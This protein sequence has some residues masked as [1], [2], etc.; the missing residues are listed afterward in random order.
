M[1]TPPPRTIADLDRP[2]PE[3]VAAIRASRPKYQ[4]SPEELARAAAAAEHLAQVAAGLHEAPDVYEQHGLDI[5][6]HHQLDDPPVPPL[7]VRPYLRTGG[8]S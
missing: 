8:Q 1:T 4:P 6:W 5:E 3:L 2:L 7:L